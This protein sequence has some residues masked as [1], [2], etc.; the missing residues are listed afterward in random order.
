[1]DIE[2]PNSSKNRAFY[3]ARMTWG[4]Q[5]LLKVLLS[6]RG[7]NVDSVCSMCHEEEDVEHVLRD[8]VVTREIRPKIQVPKS[9]QA[10]FRVR[11]KE[12]LR[13]N[14]VTN[15]QH[16]TAIPWNMIF[17]QAICLIWK[18]RCLI[19]FQKQQPDLSLHKKCLDRSREF[20]SLKKQKGK[21]PMKETFL[22][23][24]PP[25]GEWVK[26]NSD[27]AADQASR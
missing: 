18:Q 23:W 25:H 21:D 11:F 13:V 9:R 17:L 6:L 12:R 4:S 24:R 1:M 19:L 15:E 10:T 8:C 2:I 14:T 5:Y 7:L 16:A 3:V 27:G 20:F 26:L 22:R